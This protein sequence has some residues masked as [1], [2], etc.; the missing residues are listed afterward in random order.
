[1][2]KLSDQ[3]K[4]LLQELQRDSTLSLNKIAE[5]YGMAQSTAW[6]KVRELEKAGVIR[7]RV[8]LLDPEKIGCDLTVLASVTLK[9]HAEESVAGFAR[10]IQG[11]REILE[12]L[13]VSGGADYHLKIRV[14]DVSDYE[15]FMTETL[16]RSPLVSA[17][18]SSLVLKEIKATTEL[19][20]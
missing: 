7:A 2:L 4:A 12:C 19:P 10:L 6:R 18:H 16:L 1:M 14:A 5:T 17:L 13:A 9:D 8:A 11:R 3:E 20:L 15:R